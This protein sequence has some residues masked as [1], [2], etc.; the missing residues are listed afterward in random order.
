MRSQQTYGLADRTLVGTATRGAVAG[1]WGVAGMAGVITTL[2]RALV[3]PDEVTITHP[4]K[5]VLRI[6]QALGVEDELDVMTRRRLG[7]ALHFGFGATWGAVYA[8]ATR[9]REVDP[10]LGGAAAGSALWL[11]A[12]WGYMPALG[13]HPGAWTWDKREYVLTGSA[14]LAFGM[15]MATVL[16]ALRRRHVEQHLDRVD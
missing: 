2:R 13:V 11:T 15:T 5:V 16:K 7:D 4:E 10:L 9:K 6:R 8:I 1:L 3:P 14:H 12:F